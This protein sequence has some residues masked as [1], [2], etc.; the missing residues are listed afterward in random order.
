MNVQLLG[1]GGL[2][3]FSSVGYRL[4]QYRRPSLLTL[5]LGPFFGVVDGTGFEPVTPAV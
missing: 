5:A 4:E 2:Q 1:H 3:I